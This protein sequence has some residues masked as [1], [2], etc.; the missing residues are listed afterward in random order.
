MITDKAA[1]AKS[2]GGRRWDHPIRNK[3]EDVYCVADTEKKTFTRPGIIKKKKGGGKEVPA[4]LYNY[5]GKRLTENYL[6]GAET[7]AVRQMYK[8]KLLALDIDKGSKYRYD[9]IGI[10]HALE[11]IGLCRYIKLLS[12]DSGGLHIYFPLKVAVNSE[13]LHVSTKAWLQHRGYEVADGTLEIFPGPRR[14]EWKINS[15]GDWQIEHLA[16]CFRLPLQ[17]GSYVIDEDEG[18][19]H[20]SKERFW[21]EEFDLCANSQDTEAFI[22]YMENPTV[23]VNQDDVEPDVIECS[24]PKTKKK[25]GRPSRVSKEQFAL[26]QHMDKMGV[27]PRTYIS[28]LR[29]LV[30]QGWTDTSQS[31]TL[32]GAVAIL[33]SYDNRSMDEK[34]LAKAIQWEARRL[35]GYQE[36]A[37]PQ[38]KKDLE[39]ASK[40][41]WAYRWAKSVIKYRSRING[42]GKLR[43]VSA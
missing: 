4:S 35:P 32:I 10:I 17:E 38:T 21:L 3:L 33:A 19:V 5:S 30:K 43:S 24:K 29:A 15:H 11:E 6:A 41:S 8:I 34:D 37:S 9:Y 22:E 26:K 1:K 40:R 27:T 16:R 2:G 23:I 7:L 36:Y 14:T 13:F 18:I 42:G 12:S 28:E 39:S 31:N 25:P 20:N